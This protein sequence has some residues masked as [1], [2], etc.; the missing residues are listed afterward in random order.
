MEYKGERRR[1]IM[2]KNMYKGPMDKDN[3]AGEG[4]NMEGGGA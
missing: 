3:G 2:L 1:R 4:L